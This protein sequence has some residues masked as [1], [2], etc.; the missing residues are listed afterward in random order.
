[1]SADAMCHVAS[2]VID[3]PEDVA[4]DHLTD[5]K[6]LGRWTLGSMDMEPTD[7]PNVFRSRS[8][9][10]GSTSYVEIDAKPADGLIDFHVGNSEK[11][12]PRVFVR[13]APGPLCGLSKNQCTV[14]LFAWRT[15]DMSPERWRQLG[16][17]H[18]AEILLFKAQIETDHRETRVNV[19]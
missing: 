14:A 3:A 11:R 19:E 12:A 4:F 5:P 6:R 2:V 15:A 17:I 9:F 18:D 16:V 13:V 7:E 10:D 1:M 8:L